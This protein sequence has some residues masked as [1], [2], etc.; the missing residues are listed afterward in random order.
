MRE[1]L[2]PHHAVVRDAI[3]GNGGYVFQIV[4]DA[5]AAALAAQRALATE[6]WKTPAPILVRMAVHTG[7]AEVEAGAY[8]SGEYVSGP[9]LNRAARLRAAAHGGQVVISATTEPLVRDRLP[10]DARLEDLG[11]QQLRDLPTP[12]RIF[13]VGAPAD[14]RARTA[15]MVALLRYGGPRYREGQGP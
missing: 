13:R 9:T 1:A 15:A 11:P 3:H 5:I 8:Q 7:E 4:G 2:A 14:L 10:S 6:P 12:A